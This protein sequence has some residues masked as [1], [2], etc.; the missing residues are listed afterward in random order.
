MVERF[1]GRKFEGKGFKE[2]EVRREK[3]ASRLRQ[4]VGWFRS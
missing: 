4:T 1:R 3:G 2:R